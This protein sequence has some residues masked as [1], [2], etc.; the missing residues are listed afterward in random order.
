MCV[1]ERY[2]YSLISKEEIQRTTEDSSAVRPKFWV[3]RRAEALLSGA[4]TSEVFD[5]LGHQVTEQLA[6]EQWT[7]LPWQI[8]QNH[9]FSMISHEIWKFNMAFPGEMFPFLPIH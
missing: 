2:S 4:E 6:L 5:G 9:G 8:F 3:S 1:R 7:G